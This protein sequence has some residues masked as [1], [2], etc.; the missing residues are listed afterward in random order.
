MNSKNCED[1]LKKIL[2]EMR[3]MRKDVREIQTSVNSSS[4]TLRKMMTGFQTGAYPNDAFNKF[5]VNLQNLGQAVSVTQNITPDGP[6]TS[7]SPGNNT[8][9]ERSASGLTS[10]NDTNTVNAG[11]GSTHVSSAATSLVST[12]LHPGGIPK[13]LEK[14]LFGSMSTDS[15]FT[16]NEMEHYRFNDVSLTISNDSSPGNDQIP[17]RQIILQVEHSPTSPGSNSERTRTQEYNQDDR[18]NRGGT[19]NQGNQDNEDDTENRGGSTILDGSENQGDS[20]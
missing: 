1:I 17:K 4:G 5:A 6:K 2:D 14:Q 3:E 11:S 7:S 12:P 13:E 8:L 10:S 16:L 18:E 19:T 15:S 9:N 20:N